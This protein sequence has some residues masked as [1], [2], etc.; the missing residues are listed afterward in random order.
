MKPSR[1]SRPLLVLSL[2]F[3]LCTFTPGAYAGEKRIAYLVSDA[4]IPFW[5]IMAEGI[6]HEAE[7]LGYS[8]SVFSADNQARKELEFTAKAIEEGVEGII[9]SPTNSSAAVTVLKLAERAG[10]PVVVSDIGADADNYVSYIKSDNY[11]GAYDLGG[12]LA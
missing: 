11:Q 5:G 6:K 3:T 1:F 2:F 8:V 7:E 4:R 9:L 12:I 10:I